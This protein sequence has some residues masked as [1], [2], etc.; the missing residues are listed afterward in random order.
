[1]SRALWPPG[2]PTRP[3]S[4]H[5]IF[6]EMVSVCKPPTW[7]CQCTVTEGLIN[8]L[9][10]V[11]VWATR[12]VVD[13][14]HLAQQCLILVKW[15]AA[16]AP[17]RG[18][19]SGP[20]QSSDPQENLIATDRFQSTAAVGRRP[21]KVVCFSKQPL[22]T[23]RRR[24]TLT[25]AC[26]SAVR[27]GQLALPTLRRH[28]LPRSRRP[29]ADG[30]TAVQGPL[31]ASQRRAHIGRRHTGRAWRCVWLKTV[32]KKVSTRERVGW[33]PRPLRVGDVCA[34]RMR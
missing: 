8:W 16:Y 18:D 22:K 10:A 30:R 14:P 17:F 28:S 1:M 19:A 31:E 12:S 7:V 23:F 5:A 9:S 27:A 13:C 34:A 25:A 3:A 20:A 15:R 11:L 6:C 32:G 2:V 21:P 4:T 26:T 33:R 29:E 24:Q